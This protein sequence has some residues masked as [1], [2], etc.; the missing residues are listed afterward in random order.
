MYINSHIMNRKQ[1]R[2][3]R[4][5][6]PVNLPT[7]QGSINQINPNI[8]VAQSQYQ[9]KD[10][11]KVNQQIQPPGIKFGFVENP[12][13]KQMIPM[14]NPLAYN[15]SGSIPQYQSNM[16]NRFLPQT[17]TPNMENLLQNIKQ[18]QGEP[19]TVASVLAQ[20]QQQHNHAPPSQGANAV[21][22]EDLKD[23]IARSFAK[24]TN[25]KER[26]IT[27]KALIKIITASKMNGDYYMRNWKTYQLPNLPREKV[28]FTAVSNNGQQNINSTTGQ[29]S[30]IFNLQNESNL[31][32][33][34]MA[35]KTYDMEQNT[36]NTGQFNLNK[37][38]NK[39]SFKTFSTEGKIQ[40]GMNALGKKVIKTGKPQ[41]IKTIVRKSYLYYI[42]II[43][44]QNPGEEEEKR[45]LRKGRFHKELVTDINRPQPSIRSPKLTGEGIS[46]CYF[47]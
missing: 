21:E 30:H 17:K 16:P 15:D 23:Y 11:G 19:E 46:L 3:S 42:F 32:T 44:K 36:V 26:N 14:K 1:K 29:L 47:T 18:Q 12:L 4:W 45:N 25:T 37:L 43:W 20:K 2:K 27:E 9:V 7:M 10:F 8:P 24:C 6:T 13:M 35:I 41:Q 31:S 40:I 5:E 34:T 22:P 28:G 39:R 33:N 38:L